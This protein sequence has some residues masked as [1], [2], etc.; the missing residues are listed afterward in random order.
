MLA[1]KVGE[2]SPDL[3]LIVAG[4]ISALALLVLV[5][6]WRQGLR[7]RR[8]AE[9]LVRLVED[10]PHRLLRIGV[11]G[12]VRQTVGAGPEL[13]VFGGAFE[14]IAAPADRAAAA[15]ALETARRE[16]AAK[17]VVAPEKAP[18]SYLA[19]ELRR[20]EDG[21]L[22]AHLRDVTPEQAYAAS[23]EAALSEAM[24]PAASAAVGAALALALDLM[25][26]AADARGATIRWA[27]RPQS[28]EAAVDPLLLRLILVSVISSALASLSSGGR[29][30]ILAQLHGDDVE[31][32]V[33]D[34][35]SATGEE[36][37]EAQG[38]RA[39]LA[40][41]RELALQSGGSFEVRSASGVGAVVT[42]RLPAKPG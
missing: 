2:P 1:A 41:A 34:D 22:A 35:G 38:A 21:E 17:V 3:A 6:G 42:V 19:I 13:F 23:L 27:M 8:E 33:A 5:Y 15:G 12:I 18:E 10:G 26:P 39:G 20:L 31:L 36:G 4:L 24:A 40:H 32:L 9:A 29:I 28:L 30:D 25:K 14:L 16:G 11:D 7:A 37:A